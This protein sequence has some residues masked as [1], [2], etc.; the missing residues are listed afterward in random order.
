[1]RVTNTYITKDERERVIRQMELH[2][3]CIM[4]LQ[5]SGK[6]GYAK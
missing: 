6:G 1:M 3:K 5:I 4:L 2:R